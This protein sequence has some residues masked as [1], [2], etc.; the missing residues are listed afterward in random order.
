M[1]LIN[2]RMQR[3]EK[4]TIPLSVYFIFL[5]TSHLFKL[6][7]SYS[8]SIMVLLR[9]DN[10]SLASHVDDSYL[11]DQCRIAPV[12]FFCDK[13]NENDLENKLLHMIVLN[14]T[15]GSKT[16]VLKMQSST[17]YG[18]KKNK[19]SKEI[20]YNRFWLC[21]D[22]AS[23]PKC[24][25]IITRTA[26]DSSYLLRQTNGLTFVGSEYF[27]FEPDLTS[28]TI[29]VTPCLSGADHIMLLPCQPYNHIPST[30]NIMAE[31]NTSG[32]TEYFV[33]NGK[34]I[35]LNR[36]KIVRE[37]SCSGIQ[38]DRQK[39]KGECTCLHLTSSSS[40]VC[41]FDVKFPVP[42]RFEAS[43]NVTVHGFRSLR[44]TRIFFSNF[45]DH[46]A[47]LS[48][49]NGG[50]T[51]VGWYMKGSTTDPTNEVEKIDNSSFQ[52]H[53]S[54]LFPTRYIDCIKNNQNFLALQIGNRVL[55]NYQQP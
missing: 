53:I 48:P 33:L 17:F 25:A 46:S 26:Q 36:A 35:E 10:E 2:S 16:S 20:T 11:G 29:G 28:Q 8:F 9:F 49:E 52:I 22:L 6:V 21:A 5:C 15:S 19:I 45:E 31:P 44:T 50:W 30:E 55:T 42:K 1:N 23:P 14:V 34:S 47:N 40:L 18:A 37:V 51:I 39:P 27:I 32:T 41:S 3:Q 43:L 12:S 54:Y 24:F 38:C 4:F 7:S 13:E